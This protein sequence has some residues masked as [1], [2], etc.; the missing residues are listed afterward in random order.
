MLHPVR[1]LT[2]ESSRSS[3]VRLLFN[4]NIFPLTF[5]ELGLGIIKM[6]IFHIQLLKYKILLQEKIRSDTF[7]EASKLPD[8]VPKPPHNPTIIPALLEDNSCMTNSNVSSVYARTILIIRNTHG[9]L[10]HKLKKV[11]QVV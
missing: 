2:N 6:M 7:M 1:G 9:H 5:G 8:K 10:K 3:Y 11:T 4:C